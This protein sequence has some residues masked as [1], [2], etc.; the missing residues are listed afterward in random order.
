MDQS[1]NQKDGKGQQAQ[2]QERS[3]KFLHHQYLDLMAL[4][5]IQYLQVVIPDMILNN[6]DNDTLFSQE[7]VHLALQH[8]GKVLDPSQ[9]FK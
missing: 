2:G 3:V 1:A 6:I 4:Y 8:A 7:M 9:N 5:E